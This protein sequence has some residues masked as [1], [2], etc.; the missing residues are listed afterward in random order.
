[1]IR[2][3]TTYGPLSRIKADIV[4]LLV[5][6][7]RTIFERQQHELRDDLGTAAAALEASAFKGKEKESLILYPSRISTRRILLVGAGPAGKLTLENLRRASAVAAK[8]ARE[9]RARTLALLE[10]HPDAVAAAKLGSSTTTLESI[11]AAL[12][13]G[14]ALSLYRFDKYKTDNTNARPQIT[15]WTVVG[16]NAARARRL[17]TGVK[18]AA[19]VT[20]ATWLARDLAN[21]PGNEIYPAS[22]AERARRIGRATGVRVSVF[23]EGQ[24]RK[25][26]MGGLIGVSRGSAQPPRFIVM[27]YNRRQSGRGTI[28]LVGKGV[29]FDAGGISIKPAANMSEMKMDMAGGAAVLATL[30]AAAQLRLPLRIVGL[31]PAT[32]NLPGGKALKPGDILTHFNGTTSEIENTDAE[33]RLILADALG[34]AAKFNPDLV[35]DLA[36]LTGAVVVALGN[37]ATGMFGTARTSMDRLKESGERTHERVWEMPLF[38]EYDRLIRSDVADVKNLGGRWA[39]AITAAMFLK[40]FAGNY[41]W[42][43]LDIAGTAALDEP[44]DYI[45]KGATG[46]GVRL[47]VDFLSRW[48]KE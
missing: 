4:A 42:I 43:H 40:K 1:M 21:A 48:R 7:D 39:G 26:G 5:F 38:E 34:Y 47:L 25:L 23:T 29:T 27:D 2:L 18:Q 35:I 32:E 22:L 41:P 10:P 6:E 36:T 16:R 31:V 3:A 9:M 12:A 33:G 8:T 20:E 15:V 45:P 13:E 30:R 11:G 28:V 24:I 37:F 14:A 17:G 46:V 19:V 44:L